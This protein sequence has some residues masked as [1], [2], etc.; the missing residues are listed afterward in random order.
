MKRLMSGAA[1]LAALVMLTACGAPT[2]GDVVE[3]KYTP[4]KEWTETVPD[5]DTK[6]YSCTKYKTKSKTV[7]GKTTT[8]QVP[9]SAT[10]TKR[11]RDGYDEVERYEPEEYL[12]KIQDG[13]DTGWVEVDEGTYNE[14]SVGDYYEDGSVR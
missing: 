13:E 14:A 7:N 4:E 2:S 11:V 12:L 6:T 1:V 10:C 3:K 5:Y 8:E 9:Y